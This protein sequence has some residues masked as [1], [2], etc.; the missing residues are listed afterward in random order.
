MCPNTY[1]PALLASILLI[2]PAPAQVSGVSA[3]VDKKIVELHDTLQLQISFEGAE[4]APSMRPLTL[5]NFDVIGRPHVQQNMQ[6]INGRASR[7]LTY[8]YTLRPKTVGTFTIPAFSIQVGAKKHTTQPIKVKVIK[9]SAG[10]KMTVEEAAFVELAVSKTDAYVYEQ[11][12]LTLKVFVF[13]DFQVGDLAGD[14]RAPKEFL[15]ED[16]QKRGGQRE[17][18]TTR[19]GRIYRV[20]EIPLKALFPVVAGKLTIPET[21]ITGVLS[22]P[23]TRR[24]RRRDPRGG[25]FDDPFGDLFGRGSKRY[26]LNMKTRPVVINVKPLPEDGRPPKFN[27]VIGAYNFHA[28]IAPAKVRVG[29]G[30][31]LT[32]VVS[33]QG[34]IKAV[35]EPTLETQEGFKLYRSEMAQKTTF[36]RGVFGG[37][38]TFKKIIEPQSADITEV[39][40]AAFSFFDPRSGRYKTIRRGPFPIEVTPSEVERPIAYRPII[41][42]EASKQEVRILTED[43]LPIMTT[44]SSFPNQA[45]R[46]HRNPVVLGLVAVPPVV[47]LLSLL[48]QRKRMRLITDTSYARQRGALGA[49]RQRLAAAKRLLK[50][51]EPTEVYAAL[52]HALTSFIADKLDRPAASVSPLSVSDL[53]AQAGVP[54]DIVADTKAMLESCDEARFSAGGK[55][56]EELKA[57]YDRVAQLIQRLGKKL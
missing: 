56:S 10:G 34:Y 14:I 29:D 43:I 38:K 36:E 54:E 47:L 46:L 35:Q 22:V 39:P 27:E 2:A 28:K 18:Q 7:T 37:V 12:E 19:S 52:A 40:A 45:V 30:I 53:L 31:T 26:R 11:L 9:G 48:A 5:G 51:G 44:Y 25:F 55:S 50:D 33:G 17:I 1:I 57:E 4:R 15:E 42:D 3:T 16:L 13:R 41:I 49:G 23:Q 32:M 21:T 6:F 24:R 20:Q 8:V